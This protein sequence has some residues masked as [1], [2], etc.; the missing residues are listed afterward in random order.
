MILQINTGHSEIVIN[1]R[2]ISLSHGAQSCTVVDN[3]AIAL[4]T[5]WCH[6]DIEFWEDLG[7]DMSHKTGGADFE[8]ENKYRNV[9]GFDGDAN[10]QW[11]LPEAPHEP[12]EDEEPYYMSLWQTD[13]SL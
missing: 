2:T 12:P 9:V 10:P 8:L 1:N 11:I 6:P 3:T 4:R 5:G 7:V 13:G